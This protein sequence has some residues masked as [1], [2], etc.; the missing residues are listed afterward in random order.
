MPEASINDITIA[1]E[2]I[3]SENDIPL[4]LIAGLSSQLVTWPDEFCRRLAAAGHFVIR[5]DNRDCGLSS[6]IE[7]G[8]V[9]DVEALMVA[10]QQGQP[11]DPPYTLSD[12]AADAVGLLDTLGLDRVHVC[13][14]SMGGMIAQ[15]MAIDF[16][17]R[18]ASMISMMESEERPSSAMSWMLSR[19]VAAPGDGQV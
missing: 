9:P 6:K 18:V 10:K 13:G 4:L 8:G 1:Y 11:I 16:P 3:G 15:M 17:D 5:F 14:L 2:T 19:I 7:S 12:M